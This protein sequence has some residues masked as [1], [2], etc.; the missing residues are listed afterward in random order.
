MTLSAS[1]VEKAKGIALSVNEATEGGTTLPELPAI[2]WIVVALIGLVFCLFGWRLV[3]PINVILDVAAGIFLGDMLSD[4]LLASLVANMPW[5]RFV[6]MLV[7]GIICGYITHKFFY[8]LL[9]LFDFAGLTISA[10][11]ALLLLIPENLSIVAL[12]IA[13]LVALPISIV[14]F[15]LIIPGQ[16]FIT[17]LVG[18]VL[19]AA[20]LGIM[21]SLQT[22]IVLAVLGGAFLI[23]AI[24]QGRL[25]I[26]AKK[27]L[28]LHR[29]GKLM[30]RFG[31]NVGRVSDDFMG[32]FR[33][34]YKAPRRK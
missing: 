1:I 32:G 15:Q 7:I 34:T 2:A 13:V 5:L 26:I 14:L 19:I 6:L 23:G 21:L 16:I 30:T 8:L 25:A 10:D 12:I 18:S 27:N 4:T 28:L 11:L 9:F 24:C 29:F 33:K 31:Y 22:P 20:S 3:R 17:D